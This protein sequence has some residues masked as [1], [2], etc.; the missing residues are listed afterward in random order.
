M[1][2]LFERYVRRLI[3]DELASDGFVVE[4]IAGGAK[5]KRLFMDGTG[6]LLPDILV[7]RGGNVSLIVDAKYKPGRTADA[8]NYYQITTYLRAYNCR[9]GVLV[10]P[11]DEKQRFSY[12]TRKVFWDGVELYEVRLAMFDSYNAERFLREFIRQEV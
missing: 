9:K 5:A 12:K 3:M 1:P 6:E 10:L 7:S 2:L 4:K 11:A 8:D